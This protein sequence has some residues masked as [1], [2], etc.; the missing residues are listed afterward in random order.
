MSV[1]KVAIV[2]RPNVGKSSIFNW[3]AGKMI[4]IVD[5]AAGVTRDR[6]NYLMHEGDRY[7]ELVDTGGIGVEDVDNLTDEIAEQI[8]IGLDEASL[9][10]F[11][12]DGRTG[13]VP[14][15]RHVAD[16]LRTIQKPKLLVVNKCDSQRSESEVHEFHGLTDGPMVHVSVKANRN[17]QDLLEAILAQLPAAADFEQTEGE[18]LAAEPE[19]KL[20]IVGRRNVGKSTFINALAQSERVIVSEVPGT[21]RDSIDIR[22]EMDEKSFIAIDTAGV[23]RRKSLADD[24]EYYALVRAKRSIR[25]ADVVLM[26]FDSQDTISKVDRQLVDEIYAGCKPCIFVVNKW[27]LAGEMTTEAWSNYLFRTFSSMRHVPVAFVTAQ[28]G[29]NAKQLVN[30]AQSIFKQARIRVPTAELNRLVRAAIANNQPP[31]RKNR[32]PKIFFA[33]QVAI[34]PPTIVVKVNDPGLFDESWKRYLLGVLREE[35]PFQEV[36]IRLYLR[37]RGRQDAEA[38]SLEEASAAETPTAA[39]ANRS[40]RFVRGD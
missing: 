19:M 33:T 23:R 22:F 24:V 30:L 13:L 18:A 3:L 20:A 6:V 7:F 17:R 10:V 12:V 26:F 4:V 8:R 15:D 29:K 16:R 39:P 2:G 14:L 5:P 11:V 21:T 27:D 40:A 36:P 28:T 32:H 35:L 37:S 31:S 25:R 9:I 38:T 34:K 1:P